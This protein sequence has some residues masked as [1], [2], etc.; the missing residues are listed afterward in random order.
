MRNLP[1][2]YSRRSL[3]AE[4]NGPIPV[5]THKESSFIF[6]GT[7]SDRQLEPIF[8]P[9]R[10]TEGIAVINAAENVEDFRFINKRRLYAVPKYLLINRRGECSLGWTQVAQCS[11]FSVSET[12]IIGRHINVFLTS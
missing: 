4:L 7:G 9:S 8:G 6:D 1:F 3:A 12:E 5:E 2:A 10:F 11:H